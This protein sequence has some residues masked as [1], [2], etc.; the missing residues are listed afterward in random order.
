M[1]WCL[2]GRVSTKGLLTA[3]KYLTAVSVI[4]LVDSS[5]LKRLVQCK[6]KLIMKELTRNWSVADLAIIK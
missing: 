5:L 4:Y 1:P 6:L 2:V 3:P